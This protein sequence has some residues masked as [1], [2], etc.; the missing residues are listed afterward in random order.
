MV[1]GFKFWRAGHRKIYAIQDQRGKTPHNRHVRT[2]NS[3]SD[4]DL[5]PLHKKGKQF[6]LGELVAEVKDM[7]QY[8]QFLFRITDLPV[9][10][11]RLLH[12][13]FMCHICRATPIK[14]PVI[15]ARCCKR[16]LGCQTCMVVRL[17]WLGTVP[18]AG[19]NVPTPRPLY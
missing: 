11:H 3:E 7:Q 16:I 14:P 1:G 18:F 10:L 12:D 13:T 2:Y 15:F 6:H 4:D 17:G 8:L 9:G 5:E 19:L